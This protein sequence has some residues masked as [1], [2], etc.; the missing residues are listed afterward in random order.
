MICFYHRDREAVGICGFCFK[1]VCADCAREAGNRLVC[2]HCVE[3][4]AEPPEIITPAKKGIAKV[5]VPKA[6]ILKA[7]FARTIDMRTMITPAIAGGIAMGILMGIPL[8]NLSII[9]WF[10]G[11]FLS[12]Y[13]LKHEAGGALRV[14]D[15][16]RVGAIC[17]L[18]AAFVST[19][20]SF[21][22]SAFFGPAAY[23]AFLAPMV[24][25]MSPDNA[26]LLL[27]ILGLDIT[28]D[29]FLTIIRFVAATFIFPILGAVGG[30]IGAK[31]SEF[32]IVVA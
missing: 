8:L 23:G 28:P 18:F 19:L 13:F 32:S 26:K 9:T 6:T 20:V 21:V 17:G 7:G 15:G 12:A 27:Q 2:V 3:H 14:S 31:F 22:I 30:A 11:G 5:S 29:I 16:I 10:I 1:A 25:Y 24:K 4:G